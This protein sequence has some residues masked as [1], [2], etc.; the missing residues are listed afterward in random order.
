[1]ETGVLFKTGQVSPASHSGRESLSLTQLL[2]MPT[3]EIKEM[4]V[5]V[6]VDDP[7]Y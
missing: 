1:M 5:E 3:T 2:A 6:L 4:N 7:T